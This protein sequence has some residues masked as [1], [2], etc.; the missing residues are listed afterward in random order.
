[1]L[2]L[3]LDLEFVVEISFDPLCSQYRGPISMWECLLTNSDAY[4]PGY[5]LNEEIDLGDDD[6]F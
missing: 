3:N 4:S 2:I 5:E 1:V 6:G